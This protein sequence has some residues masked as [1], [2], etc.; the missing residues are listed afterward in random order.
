MTTKLFEIKLHYMK[1]SSNLSVT[2]Q[3]NVLAENFVGK[4]KGKKS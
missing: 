3:H 2:K 4:V 1:V